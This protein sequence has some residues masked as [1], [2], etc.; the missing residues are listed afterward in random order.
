MVLH[1]EPPVLTTTPFRKSPA[2][3]MGRS[4]ADIFPNNTFGQ[5]VLSTIKLALDFGPS[6][7]AFAFPYKLYFNDGLVTENSARIT[8][9]RPDTVLF[10]S[11]KTGYR[12]E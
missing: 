11:S 2:E 8:Y 12:F 1:M 4:L 9:L 6:K 10:V 7:F 3:C 5:D